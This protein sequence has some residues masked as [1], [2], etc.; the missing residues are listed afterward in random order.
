MAFKKYNGGSVVILAEKD[1]LS[2][3]FKTLLGFTIGVWSLYM[4][5][6]LA[7]SFNALAGVEYMAIWMENFAIMYMVVSLVTLTLVLASVFW[8]IHGDDKKQ[9][10]QFKQDCL[11]ETISF[12]SLVLSLVVFVSVYAFAKGDVPEH[13]IFCTDTTCLMESYSQFKTV[14]CIMYMS[15]LIHAIVACKFTSTYSS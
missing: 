4:G 13:G 15:I 6:T 3:G 5:L 11:W 10:W 1:H 12:A 9:T 2:A 7:A 8:L 14:F